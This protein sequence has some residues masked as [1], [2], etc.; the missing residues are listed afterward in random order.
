M[1]EIREDRDVNSPVKIEEDMRMGPI[2]LETRR[3]DALEILR[4]DIIPG[5]RS[6]VDLG[7]ERRHSFQDLNSQC[8]LHSA[9]SGKLLFFF[10]VGK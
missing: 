6:S 7:E 4:R 2:P 8:F 10:Y 1:S 9:M 3:L 5:G